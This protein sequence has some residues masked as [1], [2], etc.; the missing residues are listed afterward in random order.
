MNVKDL[1]INVRVSHDVVALYTVSGILSISVSL[2]L[3]SG[4]MREEGGGGNL[5]K[6]PQAPEEGEPP[7][8]D[9]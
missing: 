8:S 6:A 2:L 1:V 9:L 5:R 4:V 3:Y 7:T